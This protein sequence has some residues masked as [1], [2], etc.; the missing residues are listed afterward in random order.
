MTHA[1]RHIL[2][3]ALPVVIAFFVALRVIAH[4]LLLTS[5]QPGLMAICSGG[6]IIYVSLETGLPV[7]TEDGFEAPLCPFAAGTSLDIVQQ[8][9]IAAP[10]RELRPEFAKTYIDQSPITRIFWGHAPRAPPVSA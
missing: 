2:H 7:E 8:A 9:P 6:Q 5:P 4:P 3:T 10:N 1:V